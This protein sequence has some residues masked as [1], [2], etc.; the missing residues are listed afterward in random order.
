MEINNKMALK[1]NAMMSK[2]EEPHEQ[3]AIIFYYLSHFPLQG[4]AK[5]LSASSQ[6][7]LHAFCVILNLRNSYSY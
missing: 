4:Q 1:L 2:I 3:L 6:P 5:R 7:S